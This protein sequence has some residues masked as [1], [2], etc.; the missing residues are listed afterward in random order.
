MWPQLGSGTVHDKDPPQPPF[1][2]TATLSLSYSLSFPTALPLF[3]SSTNGAL[4]LSV[5]LSSFYL[6]FICFSSVW[7]TGID[8]PG[9]L[10]LTVSLG[11]GQLPFSNEN[12]IL[13]QK[14][15]SPFHGFICCRIR[16][17]SLKSWHDILVPSSPGPASLI[18]SLLASKLQS[19][20]NHW[21]PLIDAS[22]HGMWVFPCLKFP[23]HP[24]QRI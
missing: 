10:P 15:I 7:T 5:Q 16:L 17:K 18:T 19:G 9:L 21:F 20:L 13:F 6:H 4:G 3:L 8:L 14:C 11:S 1:V 24:C 23:I 22:G 12:L 2:A